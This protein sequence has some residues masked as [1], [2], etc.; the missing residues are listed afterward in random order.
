MKAISFEGGQRAA[1]LAL[2]PQEVRRRA[3]RRWLKPALSRIAALLHEWLRRRRDRAELAS[4][5]ERTLR[6]IG[7]TRAEICR[8]IDK[9][10]WRK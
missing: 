3:A 6:D 10:F 8:E 4:L 9:P 1:I 2:T 5:D 7:V